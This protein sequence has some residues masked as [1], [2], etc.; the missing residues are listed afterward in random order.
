[1]MNIQINA[2]M[3]TLP[4]QFLALRNAIDECALLIGDGLVAQRYQFP[5]LIPVA[6]RSIDYFEFPHL[7]L[8]VSHTKPNELSAARSVHV[9]ADEMPQSWLRLKLCAATAAC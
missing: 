8:V 6:H 7:P 9:F 3:A 4:T 5:A 1:M 2:G